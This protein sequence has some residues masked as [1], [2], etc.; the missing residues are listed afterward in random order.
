MKDTTTSTYD[1]LYHKNIYNDI[2]EGNV[3]NAPFK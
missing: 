3:Q 1:Y 2:D